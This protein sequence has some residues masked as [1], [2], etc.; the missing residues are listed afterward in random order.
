MHILRAVGICL[1]ASC[2]ASDSNLRGTA[3][4]PV[5]EA[6]ASVGQSD[7]IEAYWRAGGGH[8]GGWHA[9][10][11]HAGGYGGWRRPGVWHAGGCR[12]GRCW[13]AS[14]WHYDQSDNATE[15]GDGL[16]P[17]VASTIV[18]SEAKAR[19]HN[20]TSMNT[21]LQADGTAAYW[22]AGGWHVGGWRAGGWRAG[23]WRA[24][25]YGGWHR[26][27]APGAWH[28]GGC[29]FG[30]CWHG[31]GWHLE[32][33]ANS[34]DSTQN[35]ADVADVEGVTE[36]ITAR[37][38]SSE[39]E[40]AEQ[41][42]AVNASSLQ[43]DAASTYWRAGGWH[44]GVWH[45]GG[46]RAGGYRWR[47]PGAWHA[48]GCRSGRCWHASGWHYDQFA[49]SSA[50][51]KDQVSGLAT[52]LADTITSS[53]VNSTA[54][55]NHEPSSNATALQADGSAAYWHA[56]GWRAGGWHAGRWHAGGYRAGWRAPGRWHAG[57]C[58]VGG[59]WHAGGWHLDQSDSNGTLNAT[60]NTS[61]DPTGLAQLV[62][63]T[64]MSSRTSDKDEVS[65]DAL[66]TAQAEAELGG[67]QGPYMAAIE[68]LAPGCLQQCYSQ[69]ICG[70]L[71]HAISAYGASRNKAAAKHAV[72]SHKGAFTCLLEGR[73]AAKCRPLISQ[74]SRFGV[75]TSASACR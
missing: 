26:W 59:C 3:K 15:D 57:G 41:K 19:K 34:T 74:A 64:I 43:A 55:E 68:G 13:H 31:G 27:R 51:S 69:G 28:A 7:E 23:G 52:L 1:L 38:A 30:R 10:G 62:A 63:D 54:G 25:G 9:G 70:A 6:A 21:S 29:G 49:N 17:L 22:R 44:A 11:W 65:M 35:D 75:P 71:S 73:H 12:S 32:Q 40:S 2:A 45:A 16:A 67:C 56:G 39:A 46:W 36:L 37:I 33:A 20:E 60:A 8:V 18:T 53:E 66:L 5:S 61:D 50:A 72:C 48:G 14:G 4:E 58:H 42:P 24:G 47:T